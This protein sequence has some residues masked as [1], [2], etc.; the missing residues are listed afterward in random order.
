MEGNGRGR[1]EDSLLFRHLPEAIEE[2]REKYKR[3]ELWL[4]SPEPSHFTD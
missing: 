4:L 2:N 1:I 3:R